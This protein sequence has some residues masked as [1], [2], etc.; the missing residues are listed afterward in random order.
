MKRYSLAPATGLQEKAG[1]RLTPAAPLAGDS[2]SGTVS[3]KG[4]VVKLEITDQ[5]L[6]TGETALTLQ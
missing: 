5:G 3:S 4:L 2:S 6:I 1:V